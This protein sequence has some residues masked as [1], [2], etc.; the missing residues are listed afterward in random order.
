MHARMVCGSTQRRAG[1]ARAADGFTSAAGKGGK[2]QGSGG[3]ITCRTGAAS[4]DQLLCRSWG[5]LG[6]GKGR[7][8]GLCGVAGQAAEGPAQHG[9]TRLGP[10]CALCCSTKLQHAL[11]AWTLVLKPRRM[12]CGM[13]V[14]NAPGWLTWQPRSMGTARAQLWHSSGP[15]GLGWHCSKDSGPVLQRAE[16]AVCRCA[17]EC[18]H[19]WC[20]CKPARWQSTCGAS[21]CA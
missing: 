12:R 2:R 19:C 8:A 15:G 20:P 1:G 4:V 7:W 11:P 5:R 6:D 13:H 18:M 14:L 21:G 16:C 10:P 9:R 17:L 3:G